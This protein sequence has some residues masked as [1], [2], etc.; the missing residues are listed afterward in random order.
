[1]TSN[2]DGFEVTF[3]GRGAHGSAPDK[4]IDPVMIASRFV[5][6]VQAVISR[7]KD[8]FEFGVFSI[9]SI[10]GGSAGNIIPDSV[11]L[12]GTIRTY[13]PAVRE[14]MQ[15]GIRRTAQARQRRWP[16]RPSPN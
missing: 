6:D 3:Q 1:M 4:S 5:V 14:K 8:P 9:G 13:E 10:Q 16:A 2:S 7:E 15:D 11:A 12:R